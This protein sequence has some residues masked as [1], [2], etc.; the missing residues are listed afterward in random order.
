MRCLASSRWLPTVSI[1]LALAFL[2]GGTGSVDAGRKKKGKRKLGP[3]GEIAPGYVRAPYLQGLGPDSV[4]VIWMATDPGTPAVDYGPTPD[5]GVTVTAVTDG[6]RRV[7]TLRGLQPGATYFYRVRAGVRVL[8]EGPGYSFRTDAGRL[9][10]AFSFFVTGDVGDRKLQQVLTSQSILR[11]APRPELG[12]LCGDVVYKKGRSSEYDRCLMR[13]WAELLRTIPVWPALGNHDWKSPPERNWEQEWYLPHNEHYYSFDYANAH[14]IA[15]DT[16]DGDLYDLEHQVAWLENDLVHSQNADWIF[17]YF[18]HPGITCTYKGNNDA[19]VEHFVPLFDRYAVDV[20]FS[21][22]AHTYER[23][24]PIARGA[25]VNVEQDPHYTDP[26]G[27]LYIVSG[28]GAKVK[29]GR[30]TKRCGPT[31]FFLDETIVWTQVLIDAA[32]CTIRTFESATDALVDEVTITK[33]RL[34]AASPAQP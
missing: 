15:L 1:L 27:T 20:V 18:H 34:A 9:D 31:A 3:A 25:P 33:S 12:I 5:Y 24:Y 11:A 7:A 23:L 14:F 2:A 22:H 21:G 8:A 26:P 16:R 28:A 13:P 4:L 30:P 6:T 19:V 32:R 29:E 10:R 17:A